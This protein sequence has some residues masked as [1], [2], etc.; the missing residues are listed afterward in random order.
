MVTSSRRTKRVWVIANQWRG[1]ERRQRLRGHRSS[2]PFRATAIL[3]C[4]VFPPRRP[5]LAPLSRRADASTAPSTVA[6]TH[7]KHTNVGAVRARCAPGTL[8][9]RAPER[10]G[11]GQPTQACEQIFALWASTAHKRRRPGIPIE[12]S[13]ARQTPRLRYSLKGVVTEAAA[14]VSV[15][16][17]FF[18]ACSS[19]GGAQPRASAA[20]GAS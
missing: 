15:V 7:P 20:A 16:F 13:R 10:A 12:G 4:P 11:L 6:R 2:R 8:W 1:P 9:P 17:F 3:P 19:G 14:R 18:G 5:F